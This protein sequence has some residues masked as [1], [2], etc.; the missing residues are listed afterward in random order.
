MEGSED[1]HA[2]RSI[3]AWGLGGKPGAGIRL[4]EHAARSAMVAPGLQA[5][6]TRTTPEFTEGEGRF[7]T[8]RAEVTFFHADFLVGESAAGTGMEILGFKTVA[9]EKFYI[10]FH[11]DLLIGSFCGRLEHLKGRML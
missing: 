3:F 7:F 6:K 11:H 9:V 10:R 4:L 1:T 5:R 2:E 8:D